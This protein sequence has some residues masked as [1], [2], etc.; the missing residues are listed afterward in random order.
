[1][2]TRAH[3]LDQ[4]EAIDEVG[5]VYSVPVPRGKYGVWAKRDEERRGEENET[6]SWLD[7][8]ATK[9]SHASHASAYPALSKAALSY[10]TMATKGPPCHDNVR[11]PELRG[12]L[13]S[14]S[15]P[16]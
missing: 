2:G 8:L 11:L 1:M 5:S 14:L 3:G 16:N 7:E 4:D 9:L 12:G 6:I 10:T 13:A 15:S